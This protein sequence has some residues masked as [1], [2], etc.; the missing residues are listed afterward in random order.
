MTVTPTVNFDNNCIS[1]GTLRVAFHIRSIQPQYGGNS[2]K[3]KVDYQITLIICTRFKYKNDH[4]LSVRHKLKPWVLIT[5]KVKVRAAPI[6]F[7]SE[8][9]HK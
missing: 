3:L 9:A 7:L 6:E 4:V 8:L 2:I 1:N 5:K